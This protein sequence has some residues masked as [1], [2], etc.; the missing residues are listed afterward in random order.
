MI[1]R[2]AAIAAD[3]PVWP[4]RS[5][6]W[7]KLVALEFAHEGWRGRARSAHRPPP[8]EDAVLRLDIDALAQERSRLSETLR[9]CGDRLA[10][11]D[12]VI[13]VGAGYLDVRR[14]AAV[15]KPLPAAGRRADIILHLDAVVIDRQPQPTE[16]AARALYHDARPWS[17]PPSPAAGRANRRRPWSGSWPPSRQLRRFPT[18]RLVTVAEAARRGQKSSAKLG[19]RMSCL[20]VARSAQPLRSVPTEATD[21]PGSRVELVDARPCADSCRSP[22]CRSGLT[23]PRRLERQRL[24]ERSQVPA[25]AAAPPLQVAFEHLARAVIVR[26][27]ILEI[28][29]LTLESASCVTLDLCRRDIPRRPPARSDRPARPPALRREGWPRPHAAGA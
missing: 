22:G 7:P 8:S 16:H 14:G 25:A 15:D 1:Q 23:R 5:I 18:K 21:L 4:A 20:C 2:G 10:R 12:V 11:A 13:A 28:G 17:C 3:W 19:A 6:D 24:G 29:V 26:A 9:T 27:E